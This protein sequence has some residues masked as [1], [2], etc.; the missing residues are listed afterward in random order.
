MLQSLIR[1]CWDFGEAIRHSALRVHMT[2]LARDQSVNLS[3]FKPPCLWWPKF[4][5]TMDTVDGSV[6]SST[7]EIPCSQK[8][9]SEVSW[10][11]LVNTG[12]SLWWGCWGFIFPASCGVSGMARVG[13]VSSVHACLCARQSWVEDDMASL[14]F[15]CFFS[16]LCRV[17]N[18]RCARQMFNPWIVS[19]PQPF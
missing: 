2:W 6:G 9:G 16:F 4:F 18:Q 3:T 14:F 17:F 15:V 10:V 1:Q 19:Y 8:V 11:S 12:L 5:S 13:M 7:W